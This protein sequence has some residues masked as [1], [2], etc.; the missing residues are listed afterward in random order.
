MWRHRQLLWQLTKSQRS[1]RLQG[2]ALGWIWDFINPI[3][4]FLV[5]FLVI[6]KLLGLER[7]V[8]NFPLYIFSGLVTVQV[9]IS[10]L[11]ATTNSFT[12]SRQMM[13][14]TVFPRELLPA[15][16]MLINLVGL[17][18]PLVILLGAAIL[19]GWR[20]WALGLVQ[21]LAGMI[22]IFVFTYGLGLSFAVANVFIRDTVQVVGVITTLARWAVPIIYPWTLVPEQIG[23]AHV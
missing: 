23:R 15:S 6:G 5:Y 12:R 2:T 3:V 14:R 9:F 21:G 13:R 17:G 19:T 18:P 8:E 10:G 7:S 4:Q 1:K 22:L 16:R 11:N 20:P